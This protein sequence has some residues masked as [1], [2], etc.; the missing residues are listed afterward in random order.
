MEQRTC[1]V[2]GCGK[3][4]YGRGWCSMHHQRWKSH[5]D[6]LVVKKQQAAGLTCTVNNC[7]KDVLSRG[8]CA[9]HYQRWTRFGDPLG[10]AERIPAEDRFFTHVDAVGICWEWTGNTNGRY[11][12]FSYG[13]KMVRAHR[14]SWEFLVGPIPDGLEIDHVCRNRACVNPDHLEPVTHAENI[15]RSQAPQ[16]Y[17]TRSHCKNGHPYDEENTRIGS[18]GY[19]ECRTCRRAAKQ[20]YL[21]RQRAS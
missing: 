13:G 15:R 12:Q 17:G 4:H 19:R 21:E 3:P 16:I 2:E 11:G 5:G 18:Q 20:R 6:P 7:G 9:S 14:W 10:E 1:S 8:W